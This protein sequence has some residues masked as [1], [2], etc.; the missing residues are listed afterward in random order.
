MFFTQ[1]PHQFIRHYLRKH[2]KAL[3]KC[4]YLSRKMDLHVA[5]YFNNR[6]QGDSHVAM[7]VPT[8]H[9]SSHVLPA[10]K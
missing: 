5:G 9:T 8:A 4:G 1:P 10:T 2:I 6:A 7:D 3:Y